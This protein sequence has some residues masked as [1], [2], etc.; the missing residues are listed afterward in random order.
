MRWQGWPGQGRRSG[1]ELLMVPG[2]GLEAAELLLGDK[3]SSKEETLRDGSGSRSSGEGR[4]RE[5]RGRGGL[6]GWRGSRDGQRGA[7]GSGRGM[8]CGAACSRTGSGVPLALAMGVRRRGT[9]PWG[10]GS[11]LGRTK[12][13]REETNK[14]RG[15]GLWVS[16]WCS[17]RVWWRRRGKRTGG[18]GNERW[19]G[20]LRSARVSS[21][22]RD[23]LGQGGRPIREG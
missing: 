7:A 15:I 21:G 11:P 1:R 12:K 17:I 2:P 3:R 6:T 20:W 10:L 9:W 19:R 18:G 8:A 14:G 23:S 22:L 5:T 16:L 4:G 13:M